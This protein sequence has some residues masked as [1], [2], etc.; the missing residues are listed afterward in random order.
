M[1]V[2]AGHI[3]FFVVIFLLV[4]CGYAI[5]EK[6]RRRKEARIEALDRIFSEAEWIEMMRVGSERE[7]RTY[8]R[9]L[10]QGWTPNLN[11]KATV[12]AHNWK[13]EGF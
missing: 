13:E 6:V 10:S 1:S 3:V 8:E 4:G 11:R 7:W 2:L 5:K 12:P 9:L